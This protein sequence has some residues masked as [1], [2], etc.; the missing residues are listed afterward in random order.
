MFMDEKELLKE[1]E[2]YEEKYGERDKVKCFLSF[3]NENGRDSFFRTL[4]KGHITASG[5]LISE[6]LK[7]VLLVSHKKLKKL[8]QPGGHCEEN[9]SSVKMAALRELR[10]ETG[11][12]NIK[13]VNEDIFY[14]DIHK[15]GSGNAMHLHYDIC[16]LFIC[17]DKQQVTVSE[18]SDGIEWYELEELEHMKEMD[19]AVIKMAERINEI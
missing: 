16:Y 11:L 4:E 15:I 19:M 1:L 10:E 9:D 18:E 5:W 17:D 3:L 6:D 2:V 8:I 14:I 7:K 13:L 12:Q